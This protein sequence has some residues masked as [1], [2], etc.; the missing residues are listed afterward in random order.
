[1]ISASDCR[2]S[3][4][5]ECRHVHV[6]EDGIEH[7]CFGECCSK[8]LCTQSCAAAI[9]IFSILQMKNSGPREVQ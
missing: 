1:M 5:N 2:V 6:W 7:R 8:S 4:M 3:G 9:I